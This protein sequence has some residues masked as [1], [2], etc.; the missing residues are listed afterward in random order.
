MGDSSNTLP[1]VGVATN[2]WNININDTLVRVAIKITN[3]NIKEYLRIIN[4]A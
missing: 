2:G 3:T 1:I 4:S